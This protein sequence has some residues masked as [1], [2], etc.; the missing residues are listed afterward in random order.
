MLSVIADAP[1]PTAWIY[2]CFV[3]LVLG[4]LALDL[5]VFHRRAHQPSM[6]AAAGWTAVWIGVALIFGLAVIWLYDHRIAGLGEATPILGRPGETQALTGPEAGKLYFTAYLVEKS[7]SMDNVFVIAMIFTSLAIPPAFQ[8][9]VLFWGILGALVMRG[10]MIAVGAAVISSVS[11]IV[12]L[13]G[14][15]LV[16]AA[17]KMA[18]S[19]DSH[20]EVRDHWAVRAVSRI[21]PI[22]KDLHGQRLATRIDGRWYGTP[23]LVALIVIEATDVIFAV[24]SIPAVFA[25]TADPFLVFT[26]NIMAILGLRSLYFCLAGAI[27]RFRHLRTALIAVLLFVGVKLFLVH[28]PWKVPPDVSLGVVITLLVS[29]IAASVLTGRG[30]GVSPEP[31]PPGRLPRAAMRFGVAPVVSLW[32]GSRLFRRVCVLIAGSTVITIG[33]VIS[34]LPGPGL[35]V[36]GPVGLGILA[37]EF[38][39]A[40]RVAAKAIRHERGIRAVVDRWFVRISRVWIVPVVAWVWGSAWLLSDHPRVPSWIVWTLLVPVATPAMYIVYRWFSVRR[41]R[42]RAIAEAPRR[43]AA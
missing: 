13:F 43:E 10:A 19:G 16:A 4:L 31:E 41:A 26:S 5:G 42:K 12:Y 1:S 29:G 20:G 34:P 28:T 25:I 24:D 8:H 17:I 3:V 36:L 15:L 37:S 40:R 30:S 18:L 6:R 39:W 23:L 32:K 9:R 33:L 14:A 11:W 27:T 2:A 22:T 7:L 35:T 38:L 21:V